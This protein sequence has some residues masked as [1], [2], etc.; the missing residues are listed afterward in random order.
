MANQDN[1][2]F[3]NLFSQSE[4][5][6]RLGKVLIPRDQYIEHCKSKK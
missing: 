3:V 4:T 1:I 2:R 6:P 5:S